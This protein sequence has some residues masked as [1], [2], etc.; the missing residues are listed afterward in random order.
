MHVLIPCILAGG[1]RE[2]F[3]AHAVN[4][5]PYVSLS[6]H[7]DLRESGS[8]YAEICTNPLRAGLSSTPLEVLAWV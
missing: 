6:E 4:G 8:L 1:G 5:D 2:F 7:E 3:M